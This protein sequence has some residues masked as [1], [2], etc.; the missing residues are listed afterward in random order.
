[1]HTPGYLLITCFQGATFDKKLTW[2]IDSEPVDLTSFEARMQLRKTHPTEEIAFEFGTITLNSLGEILIE[3]TAE[4]TAAIPAREYVYDL[5]L[6][7]GDV[8]TRLIEG[9]FVVTPEVTR[10][11]P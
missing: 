8:V 9:P 5:E 6:V 4:Q 1:M 11:E 7:D 3:A 2:T 10:S